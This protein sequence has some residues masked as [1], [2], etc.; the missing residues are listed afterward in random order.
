MARRYHRVAYEGYTICA[1]LP[2]GS[3]RMVTLSEG[4]FAAYCLVPHCQFRRVGKCGWKVR[5]H[6]AY[7]NE[8]KQQKLRQS[9][10]GA[11]N[12]EC[13]ELPDECN[14]PLPL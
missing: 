12:Y 1:T 14:I 3:R 10:C 5:I 2:N 13:T 7:I 11:L 4:F 9:A 6:E 8:V